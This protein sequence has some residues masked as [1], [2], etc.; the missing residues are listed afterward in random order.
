[1]NTAGVARAS[2]CQVSVRTVGSDMEG[3]AS[4]Q[5]CTISNDNQLV[6]SIDPRRIITWG[7]CITFT[8]LNPFHPTQPSKHLEP[9]HPEE[10]EWKARTNL[11][12]ASSIAALFFFGGRKTNHCT[13]QACCCAGRGSNSS[14]SSLIPRPPP[15]PPLRKCY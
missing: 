2:Q 9:A 3:S 15:P 7:T 5:S 11:V 4:M 14:I 6:Y 10:S 12:R 13:N 8:H 1:M